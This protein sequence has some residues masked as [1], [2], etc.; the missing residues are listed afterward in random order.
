[1]PEPIPATPPPLAFEP[2]DRGEFE[3]FAGWGYSMLE[4]GSAVWLGTQLIADYLQADLSTEDRVMLDYS[5]K[6]TEAPATVDQADV[7]RL[8]AAG[9]DDRGIHV[10]CGDGTETVTILEVETRNGPISW[11]LQ[12]SRMGV[13]RVLH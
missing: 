11:E 12:T 13:T 7:D 3:R 1:M 5:V 2:Q 9:F 4:R 8:R 6:L 10:A